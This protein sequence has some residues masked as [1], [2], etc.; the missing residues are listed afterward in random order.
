MLRT[1]AEKIVSV[2]GNKPRLVEAMFLCEVCASSEVLPGDTC[3]L[4]QFS[5]GG[6]S[7]S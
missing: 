1:S 4:R 7:W 2:S 6:Q 3:T 5:I